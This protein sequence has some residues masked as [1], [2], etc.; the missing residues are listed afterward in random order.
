[1]ISVIYYILLLCFLCIW[2]VVITIVWAATVLFDK[3]RRIISY[4]TYIHAKGVLGLVPGWKIKVEGIENMERG[5]A[6]VIISNHQD[7]LDIPLLHQT[8]FNVRW[9]SKREL[10]KAPFVGHALL[11]HGDILVKRG[12]PASA[13]HM[14]AQGV[15]ILQNGV[16]VA[17]FPEGTRSKTGRVGRFREGAFIMAK[18]AGV[19][20]LPIVIDGTRDCHR[21]WKIIIP[22]TFTIKIL[23]AIDPETV[24]DTD[25]KTMAETAFRIITE[26]HRKIRK[27]LYD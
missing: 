21:G 5:K 12:D 6:Y 8:K 11:I 22:H 2:A 4:T 15:K 17:I 19:G 25:P 1:M 9:V 20:I 27:D 24:R 16:S 13:K 10:L 14:I 3:K 7:N 18:Q 26:E 23:P